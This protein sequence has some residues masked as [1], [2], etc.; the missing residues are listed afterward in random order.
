MNGPNPG[1]P[2]CPCCGGTDWFGDDRWDYA[3][4]VTKKG[5]V[6]AIVPGVDHTIPVEGFICRSCRFLRLRATQ[7]TLVVPDGA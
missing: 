2:V 4:L 1:S 6:E 3:L 5:S 7:G